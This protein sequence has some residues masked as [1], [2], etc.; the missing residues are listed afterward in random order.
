MK[1]YLLSILLT[2]GCLLLLTNIIIH[3][4]EGWSFTLYGSTLFNNLVTPIATIISIG[5]YSWTLLELIKQNKINHSNNLKPYFERRFSFVLEKLKD[6]IYKIDRPEAP[7]FHDN[8][9]MHDCF[10]I[11]EYFKEVEYLMNRDA[12]YLSDSSDFK[13]GRV[14][15]TEFYDYKVY[16]RYYV[17]NMEFFANHGISGYLLVVD[18]IK[19]VKRSSLIDD[20]KQGFL[21]L[22]KLEM[23]DPYI[24]YI[25]SIRLTPDYFMIPR[26]TMP[27]KDQFVHFEPFYRTAIS[28]HYDYFLT[29]LYPERLS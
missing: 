23:V 22:I 12:D 6:K 1:K 17:K 16:S 8:F 10:S 3:Y 14:Y 24:N 25:D 26:I 18:L 21:N 27:D 29:E 9:S 15:K 2:V 7:N 4:W 5:I 28:D 20:D 13:R 11:L 19:E